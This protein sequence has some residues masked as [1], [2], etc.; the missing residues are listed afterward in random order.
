MGDVVIDL[1]ELRHQQPAPAP[2][3]RRRHPR[4]ALAA[5][6]VVLTALAGG[7]VPRAAPRAPVVVP[8]ALGDTMIVERDLLH[9]V[10]APGPRLSEVRDR[11]VRT[12]ALPAGEPLLRT[13]A[14]VPGS[15]L[16]VTLAGGTVLVSYQA[17]TV[18]AEGTVAVAAGTARL[19]WQVPARLLGVS[20]ADGVVLL[21]GTGPRLGGVTWYG[22]DLA[23]GRTRWTVRPP[24]AGQTT[25]AGHA[26]DGFPRRLVTATA[27]GHVE[28]RDTVSGRVVAA[29]DVAVP[30]SWSRRGVTVWPAGDL[31]LVGGLG[32]VTAYLLSDLRRRW[33]SALDLAGRWVEADCAGGICL[34]GYRGGVEVVDRAT[35]AHRW[36]SPRWTSALEAGPHLLVTGAEG[37]EARYPL[38]VVDARTG[39]PRGDFG[40]WRAVGAVRTDGTVVGLR[41]RIGDDVVRYAALDPRTRAVRVLGEATGVSGDCR[42]TGEVLVCRR[43]DASVAIW[44]LTGS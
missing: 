2:A 6:T 36:S 12:Y 3:R 41:Q 10:D 7:A 30:P 26:A 11:V 28:A 5:V 27:A 34:F 24:G 16:A 43:I 18:A 23:T 22:L 35:G 19:L 9:V 39:A 15:I 14:P 32:G 17:D 1:G 21:R 20:A 42:S 25:E 8:A 4:V 29:V 44:P 40:G 13:T 33:T 37:L 31:V 38:A